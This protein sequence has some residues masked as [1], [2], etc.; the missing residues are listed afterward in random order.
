MLIRHKGILLYFFLILFN[1]L[2]A[3]NLQDIKLANQYYAEGD[4]D[5]AIHLYNNL[6]RNPKNIPQIHSNYYKI[7]LNNGRFEEAEKYI[8]KALKYYPNNVNYK[9]DRGLLFVQQNQEDKERSYYQKL[10]KE[11]SGD[12]FQVRMAAQHFGRNQLYEY[13]RETYLIARKKS[14]EPYTYALQ[15]ANIYRML[16]MKNEMIEEYLNFAEE[17]PGQLNSIKNILQNLL[18]EPED[19]ESFKNLM[20][21]KVQK[22]P[23]NANYSDLLIW[24][25]IQQK[26]FY[27]AFI[28]ARAVD[29]RNDLGGTALI[30]IGQI[31]L[32]NNDYRN[33]IRIFNYVIDSYPE[34]HNYQI[35]RRLAIQ[36][37]EE[38]IKNTFP[39]VEEEIRQLITDYSELVNEIGI[40]RYTVIALRSKALLHAFYLDEHEEAIKILEDIIKYPRM[41][42]SIIDQSKL[43]LGDIY[44]LIGQPWESTLL[45]FQVEK[46]SKDSPLGYEAK[47]KNAKL[48]YYKGEFGL[49]MDHLNVL[50]LATSRQI[51]NDA[52]KLSLLI[53]DN[54][55]LDTSDVNMVRYAFIDLLNF[56][57]KKYQALDSI[58]SLKHDITGHPLYDEV[59]WLEAN[60]RLE[61]AEYENAEKLLIEIS[62]NYS[63]DILADDALFLLGKVYDDYLD[64]FDLAM[65]I[66]TKI[67]REYPGSIFVVDAR[68]RLRELRGDFAN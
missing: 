51:A 54:T 18:T 60:I 5:K 68:K 65:E 56:Q 63:Q 42:K 43:D 45:Y 36:S 20:I 49:A 55:A 58:G 37:K 48:S 31:A 52:M 16:N 34:T 23:N 19:V 12:E 6:A 38:K 24:A 9:I 62:E 3:Q 15:L 41:K 61:L 10:I 29:K 57:N 40:N 46:S 13:A 11:I 59:I 35:A 47:L 64:S 7:L 44:L 8:K 30:K 67:L 33:S 32:E 27:S 14:G 4:V 50:K 25:F 1:T 17:R 28:Q 26:D 22:R 2:H 39:V 66:Y 53:K 21:E